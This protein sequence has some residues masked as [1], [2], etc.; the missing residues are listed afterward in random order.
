MTAGPPGIT[1]LGTTAIATVVVVVGGTVVVVVDS[2]V[3]GMDVAVVM[4]VGVVVVVDF[5]FAW[6]AAGR[7]EDG[8]VARPI[9][10]PP[11][12]PTM[13]TYGGDYIEPLHRCLTVRPVAFAHFSMSAVPTR[14]VARSAAGLGKVGSLSVSL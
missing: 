8:A 7:V 9:V 1:A 13:A 4:V 12:P 10:N 14:P 5:V 3:G 2:V 11:T 6:A